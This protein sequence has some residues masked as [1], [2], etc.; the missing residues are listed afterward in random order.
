MN[1]E[2]GDFEHGAPAL[3]GVLVTN[4]G[5]PDAPTAKALRR[6]LH[7]FLWDRR[8]VD[9]ARPLWW[10]LLHL[11]ILRVRPRRSARN[12]AKVW[13]PEGSPLLV[14][15]RRQARG[16]RQRLQQRLPGPVQVELAMRYGHPSIAEGLRVLRAA[17][18]RRLLVLPLY[19]QYTA[20][21]TASTLDAVAAEL[22]HWPWVPELRFVAGYHRDEGYLDAVAA[23]LRDAWRSEPP[24][25]WLLF[26]FHGLP[27]RYLLAGDPYHC[28]CHQT[29]RL[30][31]ERLGLPEDRWQVT[32]Q[33]RF[34]REEWLQPYTDKTLERLASDG[35]RKVDVV[36]PGFSAD[37]LETLEEIAGE[38]RDAFLAAGGEQLRYIPA[39]NDRD[40]HLEAL[41]ALA[42]RHMQ[43]WPETD[44]VHSV[45]ERERESALSRAR[46]LEMGASR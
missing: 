20:S 25:E 8:V 23:S 26:S 2:P 27:R 30:V 9:V 14:I 3:A 28:F 1:R 5:T 40:D 34:G 24:A 12:Y 44:D 15:S 7:E 29:A 36:C 42:Q 38:N 43:G 32:F 22:A 18:V 6:Y 35:V 17:G 16:L 4:L 41:T 39:L 46:A 11:G 31:A 45:A 33:S 19:P 21:T 10:L 13:T 37:C